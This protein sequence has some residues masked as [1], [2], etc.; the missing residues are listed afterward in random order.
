MPPAATYGAVTPVR[1]TWSTGAG[2]L[3]SDRWRVLT[4]RYK[5]TIGAGPP[6]VIDASWYP[7]DTPL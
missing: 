4:N 6:A 5:A 2:H 1:K 3:S 7:S